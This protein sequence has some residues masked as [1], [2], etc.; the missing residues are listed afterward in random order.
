MGKTSP[1]SIHTCLPAFP[2]TPSLY[3]P[4]T[5]LATLPHCPTLC[6][7]TCTPLPPAPPHTTP[8]L[9]MPH[10]LQPHTATCPHPRLAPHFPPPFL[11]PPS[12][13]LEGF[14]AGMACMLLG[15]AALFNNT[16]P[17][18]EVSGGKFWE[19]GQ[20]G[21]LNTVGM[22]RMEQNHSKAALWQ[23]CVPGLPARHACISGQAGRQVEIKS[24][25][26]A[27]QAPALH[28]APVWQ[29]S[30]FSSSPPPSL[31]TPSCWERPSRTGGTR[32]QPPPHPNKEKAG[33]L[34][35][36]GTS[37]SFLQPEM[38]WLA[39]GEQ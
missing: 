38:G 31:L 26:V 36:L 8:C 19:E 39:G 27:S 16:C 24:H 1:L 25:G 10:A 32:L 4:S 11:H 20:D 15:S 21:D 12:L 13:Y 33:G 17:G 5:C 9:Y 7:H 34:H 22:V 2:F 3:L 23:H 28:P 37:S 35:A 18:W 6:I 29:Q 30:L 14:G